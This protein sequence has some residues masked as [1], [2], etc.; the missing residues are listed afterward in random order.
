MKLNSEEIDHLKQLLSKC[1]L[2][3]ETSQKGKCI[4]AITSS[5]LVIISFP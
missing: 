3:Q 1:P 4:I 5:E 2:P